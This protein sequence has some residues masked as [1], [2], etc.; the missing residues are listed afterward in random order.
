MNLH[1]FMEKVEELRV[2]SGSDEK[3]LAVLDETERYVREL[4]GVHGLA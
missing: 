1:E 4:T 3:K 2:S